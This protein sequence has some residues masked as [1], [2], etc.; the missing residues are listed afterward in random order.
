[1]ASQGGR[2]EALDIHI[3]E[4]LRKLREQERVTQAQLGSGMGVSFQQVQKY[5]KG[6]NRVPAAK[7]AHAARTLGCA[8]S[9]FY[10]NPDDTRTEE[11]QALELTGLFA[12]LSQRQRDALLATARAFAGPSA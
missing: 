5:E 1:M 4:R 10:P 2:V 9:D 8:V 11:D 12:R 3:G 6:A 7:L